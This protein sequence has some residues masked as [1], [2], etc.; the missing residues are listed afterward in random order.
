MAPQ[1]L[2]FLASSSHFYRFRSFCPHWLAS[3]QQLTAMG[4]PLPVCSNFQQVCLPTAN[5]R[6]RLFFRRSLNGRWSFLYSL[7][8]DHTENPVNNSSSILAWHH[9]WRRRC[10]LHH[11]QAMDV[12]AEPFPSSSC[13]C[14]LHNPAFSRHVTIHSSLSHSLTAL[15]LLSVSA[16]KWQSGSFTVEIQ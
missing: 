16:D 13:L 14:W 15:I 2:S 3:M 6:L 1:L 8:M 4:A 9:C 5:C 7:S 11:P 12:F 10:F